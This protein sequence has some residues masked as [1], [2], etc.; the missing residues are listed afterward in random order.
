MG[1]S[2]GLQKVLR[3]GQ[4]RGYRFKTFD[5]G[6]WP[7]TARPKGVTEWEADGRTQRPRLPPNAR[8]RRKTQ[9]WPESDGASV[10]PCCLLSCDVGEAASA[11]SEHGPGA[12]T[13]SL[14]RLG[15]ER[16]W[17]TAF[18]VPANDE[19]ARQNGARLLA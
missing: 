10:G 8:H 13:G 11:G 12:L 1:H 9:G 19:T 17:G 14:T 18:R 7:D 6:T 2:E 16:C 5:L 3:A 15:R 4:N